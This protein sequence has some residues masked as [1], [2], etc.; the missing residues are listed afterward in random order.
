[1]CPAKRPTL[2]VPAECHVPGIPAAAGWAFANG[3]IVIAQ[4][5]P[6]LQ[7][8][9]FTRGPVVTTMVSYPTPVHKGR[10]I[11]RM[12]LTHPKYPDG[13]K[14]AQ[15]AA[16]MLQE[17]VGQGKEQQAGFESVDM[18]VW[19]NKCYQ[20]QPLLCDGDGEILKWRKYFSQF[21]VS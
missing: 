1:M 5:G 12:G 7:M 8:V 14:E 15:L 9:R 20:S 13:S 2:I 10:T 21:Y 4:A 16:D 6:G 17:Q 18:I 3:A 11:M 19:N